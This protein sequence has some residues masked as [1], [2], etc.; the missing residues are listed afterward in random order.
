MTGYSFLKRCM[1]PTHKILPNELNSNNTLRQM[2]KIQLILFGVFFMGSI[3]ADLY[4]P[5]IK[6]KGYIVYVADVLSII[7]AI[8]ACYSIHRFKC[9]MRVILNVNKYKNKDDL[10]KEI[11]TGKF[12]KVSIMTHI[13]ILIFVLLD[14]GQLIVKIF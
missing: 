5:E 3:L 1:V 2:T 12:N 7:F 13:Y 4:I 14:L 9:L 11:L 10:Y 6:F 8:I